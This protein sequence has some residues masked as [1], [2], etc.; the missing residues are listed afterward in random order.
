MKKKFVALAV[1]PLV[2]FGACGVSTGQDVTK[3][4]IGAGPFEN[5]DF[6]GC[7]A[8]GT[9]DNSPTNDKYV[10]YPTSG[11]DYDAGVTKNG[12][13]GPITVVSRDNAEM[14]IPIRLTW[15]FTTNCK[16]IEKFYKLYNRYGAN[17]N[18]DG[19]TTKGWNTVMQKVIGA[20]LDTTLDEVAKNYT[21][22]DLYNNAAAQ[23]AL[24]ATL[25]DRIQSQVNEVA[26]GEFFT[27]IRVAT[28]QK[29]YPTNENLKNAVAEEQAAVAS[30]QSAEAK[31]RAQKAQAEA[32]T[33]TA[34]AE[35]AKRRAEIS[36]YGSFENYARYQAIQQGLNPYQ[37]TYIVSGTT[38]K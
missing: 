15:D 14:A 35:A 11:R 25:S 1:I 38:G 37:P 17:L 23:N 8:P 5:P 29:P 27:N 13:S 28:M 26:K 9:K 24:Q 36:G 6:K 21:W 31:A 33:A 3:L 16:D 20:T 4:H 34:Q 19:S 30:A 2:L 7:I 22:R 10:A 18:D 12:D 32:E